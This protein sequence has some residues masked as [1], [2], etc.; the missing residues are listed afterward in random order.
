MKRRGHPGTVKAGATPPL[1]AIPHPPTHS[2]CWLPLARPHGQHARAES[3]KAVSPSAIMHSLPLHAKSSLLHP[4]FPRD[5][6][7]TAGLH[8]TEPGTGGASAT[9]NIESGVRIWFRR[10]I[11]TEIRLGISVAV[12]MGVSVWFRMRQDSN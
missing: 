4:S 10:W 2:S 5:D 7:R 8:S 12:G 3:R 1:S 6:E 9:M 11:R